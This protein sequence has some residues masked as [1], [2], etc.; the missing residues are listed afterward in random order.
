MCGT[1]DFGQLGIEGDEKNRPVP[2]KTLADVDIV[3]VTCGG[4]HSFAMTP[5]GNVS[6]ISRKNKKNEA[7]FCM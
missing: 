3:D 5:E 7:M 4:L 2:L 6:T 1:N